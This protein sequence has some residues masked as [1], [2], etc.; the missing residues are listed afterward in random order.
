MNFKLERRWNLAVVCRRRILFQYLP[1]ETTENT[2][3]WRKISEQPMQR[4]AENLTEL[5]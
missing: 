1:T 3:N 5:K 4:K 2:G